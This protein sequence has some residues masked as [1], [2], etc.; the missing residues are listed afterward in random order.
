MPVNHVIA[1]L[2]DKSALADLRIVTKHLVKRQLGEPSGV[3][4]LCARAHGWT[5]LLGTPMPKKTIDH[6]ELPFGLPTRTKPPPTVPK[7]SR[8]KLAKRW[9][10]HNAWTW[11]RAVVDVFNT[12]RK[13]SEVTIWVV[14][15]LGVIGGSAWWQL[16]KKSPPPVID[17][18]WE[19]KVRKGNGH[20]DDRRGVREV[21]DHRR[22][23][24]AAGD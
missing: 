4:N 10:R 7:P 20:G 21:W 6:P 16:S 8:W 23:S 19:P 11:F 15:L 9:L 14:G 5:C 3:G 22:G 2:V 1:R 12:I 13:A 24:A 18:G 17:Q